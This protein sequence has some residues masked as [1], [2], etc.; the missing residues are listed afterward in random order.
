M[1][2][3]KLIATTCALTFAL[4]LPLTAWAEPGGLPARVAALEAAV[5]TLG[6]SLAAANAAISALQGQ[7]AALGSVADFATF[8]RLGRPGA[9][10]RS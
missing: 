8:L 4:C 6:T 9:I 10:A 7:L 5:A 2:Q 3:R 1:K